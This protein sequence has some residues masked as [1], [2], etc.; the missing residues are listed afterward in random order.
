VPFIGGSDSAFE[1]DG[2]PGIDYLRCTTPESVITALKH[3][4]DDYE[5]R[6]RLVLEGES[7]ARRFTPDA[8]TDVWS[9]YL[10]KTVTSSAPDYF[11]QSGVSKKLSCLI[12]R[13]YV[14]VDR[15]R[16]DF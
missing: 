1:A 15:A 11:S 16:G 12:Q 10:K 2:R 9:D 5:L 13:L 3:L 6:R 8:I 7:A 4:K 14:A